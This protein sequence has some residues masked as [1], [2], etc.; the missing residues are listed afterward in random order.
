[1][2]KTGNF[3]LCVF[4][5]NKKQWG[6]SLSCGASSDSVI[7][8]KQESLKEGEWDSERIFEE[9]MVRFFPKLMKAT[10]AQI[11]EVHDTQAQKRE[12]NDTKPYHNQIIQN[13]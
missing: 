7:Y 5:H 4:C 2:V 11:Q 3:V 12:E 6:A 8:R 13:Q 10:N 1:M 9:T